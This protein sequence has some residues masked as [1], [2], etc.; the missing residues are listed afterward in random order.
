MIYPH[1]RADVL[2]FAE[3]PGAA[4]FVADL[5]RTLASKGHTTHFATSGSA[6][7]YLKQRGLD[8]VQLPSQ[9]DPEAVLDALAP[10][11][12]VV[13]TAENPESIGLRF[14][15]CA[16]ARRIP[17]VGVIDSSTNLDYRFRGRSK[18]PLAFCPD[19]VIVPDTVAKD[20]LVKLGLGPD[21]IVVG[22]H[23]HWDYVRSTC[24]SLD[25]LDR[26]GLRLRY[27]NDSASGRTVVIF[28]SEISDGMNPQQFRFSDEYTLRG[29]GKSHGRTE[30]VI[31][32]FLAAAAPARDR[33]HLVLRLHPKQSL[34]DL[35]DYQG[36]FDTVS[37]TESSLEVIHAADA[38]VGMTSMMITEAVLMRRPTL[39]ILPRECESAWLSAIKLGVPPHASDR[40]SVHE[41]FTRLLSPAPLPSVTALEKFFPSGALGH[42]TATCEKFGLL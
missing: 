4:N 31:E 19:A 20:G 2:V 14:V 7:A 3:D 27:F 28:A 1:S 15:A 42:M 32:E 40:G 35:A 23:P 29:N 16:A 6:T 18:D 26:N 5:P 10:R 17:S 22:G 11:L 30:I 37:Q 39:A 25:Q 38:V 33:L 9:C 24:R 21:R 36:A 13:G 12:I 8:A 41:Q 34:L